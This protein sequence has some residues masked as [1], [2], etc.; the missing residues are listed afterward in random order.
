MTVTPPGPVRFST[1]GLP[2]AHRVAMWEE[3]NADALIGLRC[4]SLGESALEATEI[5]LQLPRL[6][7]ARVVG[8][9]HVVERTA[10]TV[11]RTPSEAI[12]CYLTLVGEAFFYHDDGV[13][14]L[15]PGRLIICD[16]DRPFMRG[17]SRGLEELAV[18][19]PRGLFHD[20]TGLDAVREPLVLDF[21]R[22][23]IHARTL[24]RLVGRAVHPDAA[25]PAEPVDEDTVVDLLAGLV[26]GRPASLGAAHLAAAKAWIEEHLTDP[27]LTAGRIAKGVGISERHL[28]RVFSSGGSS[29]PQYVLTRRLER[30]RALLSEN[31]G[32]TVAEAA[33]R[34]GFGSAAYFSQAFKDRYGLRAADL[35][36]RARTQA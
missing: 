14:T 31:G 36:R 22:G 29:V 26:T 2:E 1:I 8:N 6:H 7:L 11:R 18:K 30:A 9:P 19:V 24:A 16:A 3:H 13:R 10:R 35:L 32:L 5:N 25:Q 4:R 23:D 15:S 21:A 20:V 12:A 28:S 27:G 17:F 34:C 33:A